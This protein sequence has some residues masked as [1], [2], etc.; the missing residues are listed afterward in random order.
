MIR[1]GILGA[2]HLGKIHLQC[3]QTLPQ[4]QVT[5]FYDTDPSVSRHVAEKFGIKAFSSPEQLIAGS[6]TVDIVTTTSTHYALA[7]LAINSG[8]HA[9][10]EKPV[11]SELHE[12]QELMKL[13]VQKGVKV[14]V[15]HVERFNPAMLAIKDMILEPRFIEVHRLSP[16]N[17]RGTEVSVVLDLMIHDLDILLHINPTPVARIFANGVSIVSNNPDIANARIEWENGCVANVT[18]SRISLKSMRKMRLFQDNAYV[19][20]DFL[21]KT[22]Q[23][24]RLMD[25]TG[26]AG[27]QTGDG[28]ILDTPKG[29]RKVHIE[30]PEVKQENAIQ[31]EFINFYKVVTG[32][33]EPVV[34]LKEA[35]NALELAHRISESINK[36]SRSINVQT[37]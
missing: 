32:S 12:A 30:I 13:A 9:F 11:T 7:K 21:E 8:K 18:A 6:D 2:G 35:C 19:G 27:D 36:S 3:L 34:G 10:I 33:E 23:I 5:G 15:G 28:L 16:F 4:Y 14:Q 22:A 37:E 17:P 24:I 1:I 26:H 25:A 29:R 20:I 31:I